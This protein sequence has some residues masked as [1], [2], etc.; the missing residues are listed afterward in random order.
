MPWSAGAFARARA[1]DKP[2]LLSI[3]APWCASSSEMDRTSYSDPEIAALVNDRFVPIRVDADRRP[4]ISERY[5]LGGWP[6]TAFL[7]ADGAVIGGGT[8]VAVDRM[9][10]VL[11]R[12]LEA[13][14]SRR[15]EMNIPRVASGSSLH[16]NLRR[17][18][19][20]SAEA[21]SRTTIFASFDEEHGGFGTAPKF[22]LIAPL[23]AALDAY[24]HTRE[25]RMKHIV[26]TTL[27]AM[28][29]GPLYDDVDGGFFR[30]AADRDWGSPSRAKLLDVNAG[31]MRLYLDASEALQIARYRERA[32]EVL[33]YVQTWLADPVDGGW[34][35]SQQ[36]DDEYYAAGPEAR[37]ASTPPRVDGGFYANRNATM[38]SAAL[39][40]A[41]LLD[42]TALGE[43]ALKS[44]E[45]VL[46]GCYSPGAGVAHCLDDA[47]SVRGLLEDQISMAAAQLE[48]HAATGNI[49][50]EMMAQELAHYAIRMMWDEDEGGFFDR[51][52]PDAEE[53]VGLMCDR[54]KP[55]VTNCEAARVLRRLADTTGERDFR[56]R[57][58]QTLAAMAPLAP[59]QGPLAAHYLLALNECG[60]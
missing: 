45:R 17:T 40:A 10:S 60:E 44:L 39:Q 41:L 28:G 47:A 11:Q 57:S 52:I 30:C 14:T 58:D 7:T 53:R 23:E 42:D 46:I 26:E 1:E 5:S 35:G 56:D 4:D 18:A 6:T 8:F 12:V 34:G 20:A 54:L 50:Y 59:G 33:R 31:M 51:S 3:V 43:F 13:F 29:W 15:D 27:D 55:F 9:P 36:A 25:P 2:A 49:V 48:A 24:R 38:A 32:A 16:S 22:P 19:G 37:R 21:V